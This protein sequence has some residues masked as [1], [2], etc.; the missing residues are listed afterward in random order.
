MN[1]IRT[2]IL[3]IAFEEGAPPKSQ[4]WAHCEVWFVYF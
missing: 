1:R 4:S 3:E 2:D